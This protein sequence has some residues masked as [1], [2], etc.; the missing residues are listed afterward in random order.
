[1]NHEQAQY[2]LRFDDLCPTMARER[3][4]RFLPLI[5]EFGI[6]P[7]LAVVPDNRDHELDFS[8]PDPDFWAHMRAM[9]ASGAA[10]GLHGYTH[11]CVSQGRSLVPLHRKTEFAGEAEENQQR[12]IRAGLAI[13]RE[14]GLTPQIWVAPC[15]GSDHATL[16]VLCNEGINL[17]SDGF[18]RGPFKRDGLTWIPQQLWE[19][20]EK[21]NG[22]WT[23]CVHSNTAP[24][25]L[26]EKLRVFL[27]QHAAQFTS[28]DRVVAEFTVHEFGFGERL[29]GALALVRI[30]GSRLRARIS[31]WR[32]KIG[33]R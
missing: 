5:A 28:V 27:G 12:W 24:D 19:P 15:H 7:I 14:H 11:L 23:V 26:I 22:L 4:E 20:L 10:I 8:V 2:L 30:Q 25:S 9:E 21:P 31:R 1:M 3:W 6:Q 13:L 33:K 17:V 32:T 18:A 29:C 16:R